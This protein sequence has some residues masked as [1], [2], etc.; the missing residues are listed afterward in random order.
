MKEDD[1]TP[2]SDEEAF[3]TAVCRYIFGD[4]AE[5]VFYVEIPF[6]DEFEFPVTEKPRGYGM[7]SD[8]IKGFA[9]L[10]YAKR[11]T[12]ALG[13]LVAENDDF[14]DAKKIY[15]GIH[16]HSENKYT[17]SE[18]TVLKAIIDRGRVADIEQ[19]NK[20]T[21]LSETRLRDIF[22]GRGKDEQKRNGLRSK[23]K[24]LTAKRET[25]TVKD[26]LEN[27]TTERMVYRL[28]IG[29]ELMNDTTELIKVKSG[30]SL[31]MT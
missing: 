31:A 15:E 1:R 7:F 11:V 20:V 24:A 18:T 17:S 2:K 27:V 13:H 6:T 25:V 26:T 30:S 12:N 5:K 23:C 9:A 14:Y 10:R 8:M 3:K 28:D 29:F 21:G 22:N 19:L 16:G 4:L